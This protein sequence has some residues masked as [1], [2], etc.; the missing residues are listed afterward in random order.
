MTFVAVIV[1]SVLFFNV[2]TS[3]V[4]AAPD[5]SDADAASFV[6]DAASG[7]G[8]MEPVAKAKLDYVGI[9]LESDRWSAV[10]SV[11]DCSTRGAAGS[12]ERRHA[13]VAQ[14]TVGL[15]GGDF[16]VVDVRGPVPPEHRQRLIGVRRPVESYAGDEASFVLHEYR[17]HQTSRG[18]TLLGSR[19]W[20]GDIPANVAAECQ[21]VFT[22]AS[23]EVVW[24]SDVFTNFAPKEEAGRDSTTMGGGFPSVVTADARVELQCGPFAARPGY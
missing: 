22:A 7:A 11:G 2:F 23:G 10:F 18:L 16:V 5:P 6:L 8:L 17:L 13:E 9:T 12:C 14:V 15:E 21:Y 1:V 20:T 19:Y 4:A 3:T 24:T